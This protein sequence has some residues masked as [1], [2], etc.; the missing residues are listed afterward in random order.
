MRSIAPVLL[1]FV[2]AAC[3]QDTNTPAHWMNQGTQYFKGGRYF[4]ASQAFQRAADLNP[5]DVN[6]RLYLATSLMQLYAPGE[7]SVENE[8]IAK[9]AEREFQR[10]L[11]ME[12]R[13]KLALASM[14]SLLNYK[15][16]GMVDLEE[17]FRAFDVAA[18]WYGKLT[19]ADPGNK[20][21]FYS[22]G[23][24]AWTQAS[25]RVGLEYGTR[26]EDGLSNLRRALEI[27]PKFGDAM[28]YLN[29]LY[30]LRADLRG[31]SEEGR[32]DMALA[33]EWLQRAVQ[34]KRALPDGSEA[35]RIHVAANVQA[36][37][38]IRHVPPV[39]T[40]LAL[41]ARIQGT[42]RFR[43]IIDPQGHVANLQLISGHPLLVVPAQEAVKQWQYKPTLLNGEPCE[44]V[45]EVSVNF[46]LN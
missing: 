36:A 42:V 3:A 45:T 10:A 31:S 30:R 25:R 16:Q 21:A 2:G 38:L 13:N 44:V 18:D 32:Q 17:K 4:E 8:D 43:A 19:A 24:I 29:L 28:T 7:R 35:R 6:A 15:A 26:I 34:A 33:D 39:Y 40:P 1:L 27:D 46:S 5:T 11:D 12:P 9:S 14:A 41:Q 23:V 20:D 22:L 37:N